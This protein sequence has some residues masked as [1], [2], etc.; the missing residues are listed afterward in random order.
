[1]KRIDIEADLA[2]PLE[3]AIQAAT[4]LNQWASESVAAPLDGRAPYPGHYLVA[5][6]EW[7]LI[8]FGIG[9]LLARLKRLD[10]VVSGPEGLSP[11]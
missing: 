11:R 8:L 6:W 9:D 5:D 3:D 7:K 1:M 10:E 4:L 2:C